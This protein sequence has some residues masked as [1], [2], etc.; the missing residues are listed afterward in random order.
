MEVERRLRLTWRETTMM[1]NW[2]SGQVK[3]VNRGATSSETPLQSWKEIAA[4]LERTER[5][6]RRWEKISGLPV[7][8]HHDG[9]RSTVY[10]YRSELDAWR[11]AHR[12]KSS[13]TQLWRWSVP[14]A[15][16]ILSIVLGA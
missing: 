3:P 1:R 5:T 13:Q 15:I 9:P 16:G 8:R 4:Y 14:A 10:A 11:A 2:K 12:P 6:A 7:R